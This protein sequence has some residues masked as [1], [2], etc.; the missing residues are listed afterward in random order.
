M[1][2]WIALGLLFSL[3]VAC[4]NTSGDRPNKKRGPKIITT[5]GR[6]IHPDS[7][8][9]PLTRIAGNP[10]VVIAGNPQVNAFKRTVHKAGYPKVIVATPPTVNTSGPTAF[11]HP[12]IKPAWSTVVAAGQ[13]KM[14]TA[15]DAGAKDVNPANFSYYKTLQGLNRNGIFCMLQDRI[16]NLWL[17]TSG[18]GLS[19]FDGKFFTNFTQKEGL[20]NVSIY[21]MLE[22]KNGNLWLGTEG[23]G[24]SCYDG[25]S[26]KNFDTACLAGN[27]VRSIFQDSRGRIWFGT[28]KGISCYEEHPRNRNV[29]FFINYSAN[30]GLAGNEVYSIIEDRTGKI[31][32]AC[33]EGVSCFDV[34][35][36]IENNVCFRN[37]TVEQ[38]LAH[39]KVN[40]ILEDKLG[41]IWFGTDGGG[42]SCYNG[43]RM[44]ALE[45][46]KGFVEAQ[47]SKLTMK[48][49][50]LARTF[51]NYT[52]KEGLSSNNISCILEDDAGNIWLGTDTKGLSCFCPHPKDEVA[53]YFISYTENEG[54]VDNRVNC[55][56]KDNTNNL[57]FGTLGGACVY[58][59]K[60][61]TNF[62]EKEGLSDNNIFC[63]CED[64]L[65]RLWFGTYGNGVSCYDGKSFINFTSEQGLIDNRVFS[66]FQD[67]TGKIWIGTDAGVSCYEEHPADGSH[68]RFTNFSRR[69]GLCGNRV[70]RIMED[71]NGDLWFCT[72][73]GVS[74][75]HQQADGTPARFTNFTSREGLSGDDV[76]CMM[77]DSKGNFWFGCYLGGMSRYDGKAFTNYTMKEGLPTNTVYSMLEDKAGNLWFG[78]YDG[79]VLY[80]N[81][82]SFTSF[83]SAE[84]LATDIVQSMVQDKKGNIWLGTTKG[85]SRI[86]RSNW[87]KL[88]NNHEDELNT[89]ALFY[90]YGYNDGFA[91]LTCL[92]NA[93]LQDHQERIWWGTDMLICYSPE[94]DETDT[95]APVIQLT[96]VKLFGQEIPWGDVKL[97]HAGLTGMKSKRL[98]SDTLRNGIALH[99]IKFDGTSKWHNVPENLSLPYD[100]NAIAFN[101]I[102]VHLQSRN[103][104]R[105]QYQLQGLENYWNTTE[106]TEI[107]YANLLP[108]TYT[109]IVKAMNQSGVWSLPTR[110]TFTIRSPW[111]RTIPAYVLYVLLLAGLV[112][113]VI[114]YFNARKHIADKKKLKILVEERT[115]EVVTQKN[116]AEKLLRVKENFLSN[117]SHEIRTPLNA[118]IGYT[119]LSLKESSAARVYKHLQSIK[120]S[121]DHLHKLVN[122]ILDIAKMESGKLTFLETDFD[123]RD[124]LEEVKH[125][126]HFQSLRKG[127]SLN[128]TVDKGSGTW[129][130]GDKEKLLQ[131]LLNLID[132]AIKFTENGQIDVSVQL[133]EKENNQVDAFFCIKDTGIGISENKMQTIFESFT[134]ADNNITRKYGG[135]GLGLTICKNIIELQ[136]GEI[137]VTST[138]HE[139]SRFLFRIPYAI[140]KKQES[141][142]LEPPLKIHN[143]NGFRILVAE[144]DSVNR[145]L[146]NTVLNE[147]EVT[148]DF[149]ENGE[150]LMALLKKNNYDLILMDIHMPG[151]SGFEAAVKIR[152]ELHAPAK[153]IPI[154]A[155]TAD[156]LSS[157][158][159]KI[160]DS[161]IQHLLYKPINTETL[162]TRIASVLGLETMV[163]PAQ[164]LLKRWEIK[165]EK[166]NLHYLMESCGQNKNQLL[167]IL[168]G[169]FEKLIEYNASLST[170]YREQDFDQM[171][172][173]AHKLG[174]IVKILGI[175]ELDPRITQLKEDI[176]SSNANGEMQDRIHHVDVLIKK[177]T[178]EIDRV[179][180]FISKN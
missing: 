120:V 87:E 13:P 158:R 163:Q 42:V 110:F 27:V 86:S 112:Y 177:S 115:T 178:G 58:Y 167:K 11:S 123:I 149:A 91:G 126:M 151:M 41:N 97:E 9:K 111:F 144:D 114:T 94:G 60:Y 92:R 168:S 5:Q 173:V 148:T 43:N 139:G 37:Y 85:L 68:A 155:L 59:G 30:E 122:N 119:D 96:G 106:K 103:H 78:L 117:M 74:R 23:D 61:F 1:Q 152:T 169:S 180:D 31:W 93:V 32:I 15:K 100:N 7:V 109:F 50:R 26:F 10:A 12:K 143:L 135:T 146:L 44:D 124:V 108:G 17:G 128:L 132:N 172:F 16:G 142:P 67:K 104:I 145:E 150:K 55:I 14:F 107:A 77:E 166:I 40:C 179:I 63:M 6:Y 71:R 101:F 136:G 3:A 140:G 99:H 45:N 75:Y 105:Y 39:N 174:S 176:R 165:T 134:Q 34:D 64:H 88:V 29:P 160:M 52:E 133:I 157:T 19:R 76:V 129:I 73:E 83:T 38:G 62:T 118:I 33:N 46:I 170:A 162:Y 21:S 113:L 125:L 65:G 36:D 82:K 147:W 72:Q 66:I 35:S 161:G 89:E 137:S 48:N 121:S 80:Y 127:N 102:G 154:I 49:G 156:V 164:T 57:L 51:R 25:Y 69:E 8:S 4:T 95:K 2:K 18:G 175:E 141:K 138:E 47:G 153:D 79:G 90:N 130:F 98:L 24:V 56:L 54:L 84:G 53:G 20:P 171:Y 22:D 159:E 131:V 81:G 116:K 28:N 70:L